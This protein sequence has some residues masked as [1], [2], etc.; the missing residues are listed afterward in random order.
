MNVNLKDYSFMNKLQNMEH[1]DLISFIKVKIIK[2]F[3][4]TYRIMASAFI[5]SSSISAHCNLPDLITIYDTPTINTII[6]TNFSN[7]IMTQLSQM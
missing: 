4:H 2:Y 3:Y 7:D 6:L 1:P 5:F